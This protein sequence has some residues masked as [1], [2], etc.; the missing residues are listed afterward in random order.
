MLFSTSLQLPQNCNCLGNYQ[1]QFCCFHCY[2]PTVS[3]RSS[4]FASVNAFASCRVQSR[5]QIFAGSFFR[6]FSSVFNKF[7]EFNNAV[8]NCI[9]LVGRLL[10]VQPANHFFDRWITAEME[11]ST[12]SSSCPHPS[13]V[14]TNKLTLRILSSNVFAFSSSRIAATFAVSSKFR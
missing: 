13:G 10:R 12:L 14:G 1:Y 2:T 6:S 3:L 8:H 9:P 7:F 4:F 5:M 11:A